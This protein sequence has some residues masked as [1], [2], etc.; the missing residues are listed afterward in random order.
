M[1]LAWSSDNTAKIWTVMATS[2]GGLTLLGYTPAFPNALQESIDVRALQKELAETRAVLADALE[3]K[4]LKDKVYVVTQWDLSVSKTVAVF[5]SPERA[6]AFCERRVGREGR[7]C[8]TEHNAHG[9]YWQF[10]NY[11]F[12]VSEQDLIP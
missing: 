4:G 5:L 11:N 7:V 3:E 12:T 9:R 1:I 8:W 6:K 10:D 2:E